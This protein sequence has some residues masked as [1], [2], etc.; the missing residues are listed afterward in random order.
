MYKYFYLI[1]FYL[2]V[3]FFNPAFSKENVLLLAQNENSAIES[4]FE[5]N[6][7][8]KES[9]KNKKKKKKK[10]DAKDDIRID[11]KFFISILLN[12]VALFIIL[13]L[14]YLPNYGNKDFMF[15]FFL[16]NI[17][18]FLLTY[19]LN[20]IK[21]SV[22]A[23]FGL[24]AIFSMLRYRT[25]DI[26]TKDMT[27]LFVVIAIGLI[28]AIKLEYYEQAIIYGIIILSVFALDGNI[29]M[30]REYSKQITYENIELIKPDKRDQLISDLKN[31]T[32][33]NIHRISIT[34]IDFLQDAAIIKVY[35]YE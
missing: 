28:G 25:E 35:Y 8:D 34:K 18:V 4:Y 1:L 30:K 33:L 16:F 22:G 29:L 32:G 5:E 11:T 27:Y 19:L 15:T 10:D 9:E 17:V 12:I 23:A 26:S 7:D 6:L 24:F 13:R 14:I 2:I 31:R 21:I 3:S 20:H